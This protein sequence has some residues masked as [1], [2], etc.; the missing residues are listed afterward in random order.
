M[1]HL[2]VGFIGCGKIAQFHADALKHFDIQIASVAYN[3]NLENA[4]KFAKENSVNK[5]FNN[6]KELIDQKDFDFLWVIPSWPEVE[7]VFDHVVTK[8]I[9][10]FFEK[11]LALNSDFLKDV[12][13][14]HNVTSL[15]KYQVGYNRRFYGVVNTLKDLLVN[16]SIVAITG[17]LPETISGAD[18]FLIENRL[19]Q[20]SAHF[21]D[22]LFYIIGCNEYVINYKEK[23]KTKSFGDD[24]LVNF[25][26]KD[27]PIQVSSVWNSPQNYSI[28]IYTE[29]EK[30]FCLSPFEEFN[31]YHGFDVVEPTAEVPIRKYIPKKVLTNFE[32]GN[33]FKP[34]FELQ[35]KDF[36]DNALVSKKSA[37]AHGVNDSFQLLKFLEEI[38]SA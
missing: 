23:I 30:I 19:V 15:N 9:P 14:T 2:K 22:T 35:V 37:Q 4:E 33:K 36:L 10:A 6:W 3:K 21:Y 8:N 18:S 20:N 24:H 27:I 29:S 1:S 38:K 34:G 16:E 7:K 17:E 25:S 26:V 13:D 5:I 11:P 32:A 31:V 28:K 12:L